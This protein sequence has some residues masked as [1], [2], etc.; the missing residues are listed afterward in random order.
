LSAVTATRVLIV[1][2]RTADSPELIDSVAQRAA[3]G[4]S[5]FTLLVPAA[6]RGPRRISDPADDGVAKAESRLGI[7]LPLLSAAA[8]AD[9]LGMVGADDPFAA[10]RDALKL[11]GF[12]QVMVSLLPATVSR[13]TQL[14]LADKIRAL[15][16]PV[17]EVEAAEPDSTPLS[18]A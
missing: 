13:W 3:E 6:P 18:A 10:V 9:V 5:T 11:M 2:H 7:A 1:A 16:V 14:G 17:I 4:P 15:G 12:D 8:G